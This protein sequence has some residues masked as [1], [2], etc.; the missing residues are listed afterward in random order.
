MPKTLDSEIDTINPFYSESGYLTYYNSEIRKQVHASIA[1]SCKAVVFGS[2]LLGWIAKDIKKKYPQIPLFSCFH[3]IERHYAWELLRS[4][5]IKHLPFYLISSIAE[6]QMAK[7]IDYPWVLNDRDSELLKKYYNREASLVSFF[8]IKDK[9]QNSGAL[10]YID[11]T[12]PIYLFL[13]SGF[14]ANEQAVR[15][16]IDN[17]LPHIKGILIVVGSLMDIVLKDIQNDRVHIYGYAK[18]IVPFY[19]MAD[20]VVS[21]IFYGGG[22][23]TKTAEALM[24]G[25]R[26][27]GTKEA[28]EGFKRN[29]A[30]LECN[31]AKDFISIINTL[32]QKKL[33]KFSP[34]ARELYLSDYSYQVFADNFSKWFYHKI[35]ETTISNNLCSRI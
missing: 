31:N 2:S 21:P 5:G 20:F 3:N 18:D 4:D 23:K 28:L 17:V 29:D 34:E 15:W 11:N 1:K 33:E 19:Q 9:S 22:M 14:Y 25:K 6:R 30:T 32:L 10:Q 8:G 16:F 13:G 12:C 35:N 7:Y 26:I 24:F 27:I